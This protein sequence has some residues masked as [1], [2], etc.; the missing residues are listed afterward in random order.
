M[1][2]VD[3]RVNVEALHLKV[4]LERQ[5]ILAECWLGYGFQFLDVM[6]VVG[7]Y[8]QH[9]LQFLVGFRFF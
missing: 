9:L 6:N 1:T 5:Q 8:L 2:S 4:S 7:K 3:V